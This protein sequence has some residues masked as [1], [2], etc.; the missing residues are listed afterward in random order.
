[1]GVSQDKS[2]LLWRIT[3]SAMSAQFGSRLAIQDDQPAPEIAQWVRQHNADL[4]RQCEER[5][6]AYAL[7]RLVK[8]R[9]SQERNADQAIAKKFRRSRCRSPVPG[10]VY[11]D[12]L[13]C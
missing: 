11:P 12:L 5:R 2:C 3:M 10:P 4:A 6:K 8:I 1:P 7:A 13:G 9:E